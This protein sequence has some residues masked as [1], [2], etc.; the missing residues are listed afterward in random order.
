MS[1][2]KPKSPPTQQE[3][4]LDEALEETFPASDPISIDPSPAPAPAPASP[5]HKDDAKKGHD[6]HHRHGKH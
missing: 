1:A 5:K 3:D 6:P 4:P 2:S